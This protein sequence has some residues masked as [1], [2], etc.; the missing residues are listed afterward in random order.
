[1]VVEGGLFRRGA[2]KGAYR[3]HGAIIAVDGHIVKY[4]MKQRQ[5]KNTTRAMGRPQL[6]FG[7]DART[8]AVTGSA[9][10][11]SVRSTYWRMPPWR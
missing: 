8:Y 6:A 4:F 2:A 1:M 3:S 10:P 11:A 5:G 7:V 9:D